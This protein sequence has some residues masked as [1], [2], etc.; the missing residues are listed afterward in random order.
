MPDGASEERRVV[1]AGLQLLDRQ[2][3]DRDGAHCGKVD[4]LELDEDGQGRLYVSA[5]L[6]GPGALLSRTGR[7]RLGGW[8]RRFALA[9]YPWDGDPGRIEL[10]HVTDLGDHVEIDLRRDEVATFATERWVCDHVISHLPWSD[11]RADG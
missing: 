9:S 8:L 3:I 4:D 2:L 6:C 5:I 1:D 10:S 11:R 7:T